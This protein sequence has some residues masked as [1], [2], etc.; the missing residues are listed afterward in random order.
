MK[1]SRKNT[2]LRTVRPASINNAQQMSRLDLPD[3][4]KFVRPVN[5]FKVYDVINLLVGEDVIQV[6]I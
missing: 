6:N 2:T 1:V 4:S 3:F 5:P